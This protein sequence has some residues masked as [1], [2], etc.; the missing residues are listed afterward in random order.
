MIW[1]A[2][3]FTFTLAA[4]LAVAGNASLYSYADNSG[5]NSYALGGPTHYYT[6]LPQPSLISRQSHSNKKSTMKSFSRAPFVRP[7]PL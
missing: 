6:Q 3:S 2:C 7:L 4:F 1:R 5:H